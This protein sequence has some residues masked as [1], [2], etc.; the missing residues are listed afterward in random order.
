MRLLRLFEG[1]NVLRGHETSVGG[2]IRVI[3]YKK[4]NFALSLDGI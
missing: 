4:L 1:H 3:E 2:N